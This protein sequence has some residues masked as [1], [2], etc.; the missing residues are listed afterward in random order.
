MRPAP[1]RPMVSLSTTAAEV[2]QM[3]DH[4]GT[5]TAWGSPELALVAF[6]LLAILAYILL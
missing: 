5:D 3:E 1:A 2:D 4:A 6:A